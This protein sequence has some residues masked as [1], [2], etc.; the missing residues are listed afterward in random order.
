MSYKI[1]HEKK[2]INQ[3]KFTRVSE[4]AQT[5]DCNV[6]FTRC[7]ECFTGTGLYLNGCV[8]IVDATGYYSYTVKETGVH[9][10]N[11]AFQLLHLANPF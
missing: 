11:M 3:F 4:N 10:D 6:Y 5:M 9:K 2:V 7:G 8:Y 1:K